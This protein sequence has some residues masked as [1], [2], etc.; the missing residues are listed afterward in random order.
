MIHA[1]PD[2]T[3]DLNQTSFLPIE[4][5]WKEKYVFM[6][7]QWAYPAAWVC[8]FA[9]VLTILALR[10]FMEHRRP[11][12]LRRALVLWSGTLAIF[13]AFGAAR[14]VP[15]RVHVVTEHGWSHS[16]CYNE[17]YTGP[18]AL[19]N[20]LFVLSKVYEFGWHNIHHPQ[21]TE[22]DI[23]ALVPPRHGTPVLLVLGRGLAGA[24][25][26]VLYT[27]LLRTHG[28]V[29]LLHPQGAQNPGT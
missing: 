17:Y 23:P 26:V 25:P 6:W 21:E 18:I 15:E 28:H 19:W 8:A 1:I 7:L 9:Y 3:L 24:G 2:S 29:Q 4:S 11:F 22:A 16:V 12:K 20:G 13:S 10:R 27:Q 14:T 5:D